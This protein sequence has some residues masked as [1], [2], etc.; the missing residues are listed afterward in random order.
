M[1][2]DHVIISGKPNIIGKSSLAAV[3]KNN[4]IKI[5]CKDL[6]I[7]DDFDHLKKVIKK[8]KLERK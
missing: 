4:S 7:E 6:K 8:I 3:I 5:D 1:K 2:D